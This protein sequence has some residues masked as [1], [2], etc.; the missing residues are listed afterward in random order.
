MLDSR[1]IIVEALKAHPSMESYFDSQQIEAI[2]LKVLRFYNP[3]CAIEIESTLEERRIN[4][5][6]GL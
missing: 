5:G 2:A 1:K 4:L 3:Q 6:R